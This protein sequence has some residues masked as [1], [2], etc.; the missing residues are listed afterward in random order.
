M[1][2]KARGKDEEECISYLLSYYADY[3]DNKFACTSCFDNLF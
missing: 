1:M 3:G 2:G